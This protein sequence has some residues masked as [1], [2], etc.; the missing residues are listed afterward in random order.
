MMAVQRF[1]TGLVVLACVWATG[2]AT[3]PPERPLQAPERVVEMVRVPCQV[4]EPREPSW[5]VDAVQAGSDVF[6]QMRALLAD[7]ET[8]K[9]YQHEL[10]TAVRACKK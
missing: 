1:K 10:R 6:T 5:A 8:G 7:R 4:D 3:K 2:C 9:G